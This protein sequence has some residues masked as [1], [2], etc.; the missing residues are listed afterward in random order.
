[1]NFVKN[2]AFA[3]ALACAAASI[4]TAEA[5]DAIGKVAAFK[6]FPTAS[7]TGGARDLTKG[8]E[9]FEGDTIKASGG[10][11]VQI[12]L[13]DGTKLVVGPASQLVLETYLLRNEKTASKVAVKALRGYFRF[14]TGSS[15][16][17]AYAISTPSATIG[18]RGTGFDIRVRNITLAAVTDGTIRLRG[19]NQQTVN[20]AAGCGVAEAGGGGTSAKLLEGRAKA[21][22]L[23]QDFPMLFNQGSFL[24]E[25]RL[26]NQTCK[27]ALAASSSSTGQGGDNDLEPPPPPQP[28]PQRGDDNPDGGQ[29]G[30]D[31]GGESE[32]PGQIRGE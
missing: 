13:N 19:I 16:K 28:R 14:I 26:E 11:N 2:F 27:N 12:I 8:S 22:R 1:M 18:I 3:A 32:G 24:A 30:G 29:D 17:S 20:A 5:A 6:G 10:G 4:S 31:G 15:A 9:L 25:F 7:G 23:R 21:N